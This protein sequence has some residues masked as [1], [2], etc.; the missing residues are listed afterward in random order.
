M[1]ALLRRNAAATCHS[2]V[3]KNLCSLGTDVPIG[4]FGHAVNNS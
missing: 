2:R 1:P 4:R 3:K